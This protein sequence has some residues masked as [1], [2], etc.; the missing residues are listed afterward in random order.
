[1]KKLTVMSLNALKSEGLHR[2]PECVGLYVQVS[3]KRHGGEYSA[4]NGV[5]RSWLY[6]YRS[7]ITKKDRGMGLG[8]CDCVSIAEARELARA[9]RKIVTFGGDPIEQRI[10]KLAAERQAHAIEQATRMTF[11]QCV[12]Q[13]L[14]GMIAKSRNI[15][16]Q[17]QV[18]DSLRKACAA[19]GDVSVAAIDSEMISKFL[20]PL[21]N[22]APVSADRIRGR[23]ETVLDWAKAKKF[24]SGDNPAAWNGNL[25]HMG[26]VKP[27]GQNHH[28][29]LPYA[30]LPA[31]MARLREQQHLYA[32]ALEFA[33]LTVARTGQ[34]RNAK[35]EQIDFDKR[36]WK[37]P[38]EDMKAG[39][40][41]TVPLSDAAIALLKGLDQSSAY[42]FPARY[43][44]GRPNENLLID[45]LRQFDSKVTVHG[46]RSTYS[47][48]A[49]DKFGFDWHEAIEHSLAHNVGTK[50]AQAYRRGAN[51]GKS[52]ALMQAWASYCTGKPEADN[53]VPMRA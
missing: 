8:S 18:E 45:V 35:W 7:P 52:T 49:H 38:G 17:E 1:M 12:E 37:I 23:V 51:L 33:I 20:T 30:E 3:F 34:V 4:E 10:A 15:K 13:A 36:L 5:T 41:H 40:A 32:R 53:V 24:R 6:R 29:A 27:K 26:F 28:E 11:R 22:A 39:V 50:V 42:I 44:N 2:D 16:H 19:F 43:G 48:W 47:D 21:W 9:A 14:P 46:F 25:E 31:F